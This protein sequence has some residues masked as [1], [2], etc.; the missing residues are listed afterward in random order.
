MKDINLVCLHS[1]LITFYQAGFVVQT[2]AKITMFVLV[3]FYMLV[4]P[5][6]EASSLIQQQSKP[7]SQNHIQTFR[8]KI[9]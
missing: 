7:I 4:V 8:G 6:S 1:L 9:N 5:L 3:H 2:N